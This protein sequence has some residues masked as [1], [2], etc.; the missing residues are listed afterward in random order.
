MKTAFINS[1][2]KS[3]THLTA[4]CLKLMNYEELDHIGSAQ[5]IAPGIASTIRRFSWNPFRQGYLVGIDTPVEVSR[6][7]IH[8]R[9]S[10]GR[11]GTFFTAHV[12]YSTALLDAVLSHGIA[13]I[14]VYRDPRAVLVSFTHYVASL[15]KHVLYG[16]FK[17][18][19]TDKQFESVLNG[20]RFKKAY[21]EPLRTRCLAL[22]GW[23]ASDQVLKIRFEDLVGE[24][25]GGTEAMQREVIDRLCQWLDISSEKSAG[26]A[27]ELFG[28]GRHTFRKGQIASWQSEL[29]DTNIKLVNEKLGD[30]LDRW[31]YIDLYK[32]LEV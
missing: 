18:L 3:G 20:H 8:N 16:E 15:E 23:M 4:K 19:S 2:P 6:R 21:L 26:V 32:E 31:G 1:L 11:P 30:I 22:D 13:P 17:T 24:K 29:S 28:P 5:V 27:A 12:G 14:V 9:L 10:R 7:V 25:G